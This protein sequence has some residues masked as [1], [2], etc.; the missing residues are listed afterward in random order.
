MG[1]RQPREAD[2]TAQR[3]RATRAQPLGLR[4]QRR[5]HPPPP[6]AVRY[7]LARW[8]CHPSI[9]GA[10]SVFAAEAN[11][12]TGAAKERAAMNAAPTVNGDCALPQ[13]LTRA[14]AQLARTCH[15]AVPTGD[16]APPVYVFRLL[17]PFRGPP[18]GSPLRTPPPQPTQPSTP[19]KQR[20][21]SGLTGRASGTRPTGPAMPGDVHAPT[22]LDP[23]RPGWWSAR[24]RGSNDADS[25]PTVLSTRM[26]GGSMTR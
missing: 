24:Q 18:S 26:S 8:L 10:I 9:A 20:T 5:S 19:T 17:R 3:V 2:A 4:L 12:G 7:D 6:Y 15:R 16:V 21:T 11:S 25:C 22:S 13:L 23:P 1:H 14:S